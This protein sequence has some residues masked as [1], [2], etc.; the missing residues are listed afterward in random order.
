MLFI[1]GSSMQIAGLI[2][3]IAQTMVFA[4]WLAWFYFNT[5]GSVLAT[6]IFHSFNALTLFAIFPVAFIYPPNS[7][8][9]IYLYVSAAAI[10]AI[11]LLYSGTK[12]MIRKED[13]IK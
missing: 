8:P 13:L 1:N 12:S 9:V 7:A 4:I 11:M 10:T 3:S 6:A 2:P 5:G